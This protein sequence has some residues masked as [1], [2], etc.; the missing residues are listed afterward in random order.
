MKAKFAIAA[1]FLLSGAAR[2]QNSGG[3]WAK[4]TSDLAANPKSS[5]TLFRIGELNFQQG[6]L[7][8]AA[9]SF[10]EALKGDLQPKWTVVWSHINLGKIYD[11]TGQRDRAVNEFTLAQRTNDDTRGAQEEAAIYLQ[12]PYPGK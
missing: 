6:S 4:Y 3:L 9:L 8:S 7:Q 12:F 11:I 5:L 2:G 1:F 10:S